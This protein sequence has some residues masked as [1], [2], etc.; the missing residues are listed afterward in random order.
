MTDVLKIIDD[1]FADERELLDETGSLRL[2]AQMLRDLEPRLV[3]VADRAGNVVAAE[4]ATGDT[5]LCA[6]EGFGA[7][8]AD[9][10]ADRRSVI[11][12][13]PLGQDLFYGFGLRLAS[14]GDG[15]ILGVL[16]ERSEEIES[17]LDGLQGVL[18]ACGS[19]AWTVIRTQQRNDELRARIRHLVAEQDTVKDSLE[20]S[21]ATVIEEREE[22]I[23]EQRDYVVHLEGEVERRSAALRE[24]MERAEE[25][26]RAKSE[27]LANMSHEIRTPMT[28]ILGFA[29]LLRE[30]ETLD[31]APAER[32][33]AIDAIKRNG[34]HLLG[35]INDLLDLSKIEAGKLEIENIRCSPARIIA[36][37]A[38][39]MSVQ[40][41]AR[42]L[43]LS[44][45]YTGPIPD[46]IQSDP[47]R[48]RQI[49]VNLVGNAIK[50]TDE[51]SVKITV[52][53]LTDFPAKPM[54]QFEVIDTGIGIAPQEIRRLFRAFSQ[55]D[56]ST[57]RR[58]GGTGLGLAICKR[59]TEMLGGEITVTSIPGEGSRFRATIATGPLDNVTM[60]ARP[61]QALSGT[62]TTTTAPTGRTIQGCR[63][64]LAEDAP[65]NQRLISHILRRA[66][67]EVAVAANGQIAVN[68]ALAASEE[69]S[70][71]DI[72]LMDMQMPVLDGYD[73]TQR[74]RSEGYRGPVIALTA[75]AM[76]TDRD[77][78]LDAGCD[79][80]ATKPIERKNLMAIIQKYAPARS[81]TAD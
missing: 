34:T 53:L 21:I 14:H 73:A 8:L 79:D 31:L 69:G 67:A 11:F 3:L 42:S 15:G 50:F 13:K 62:E 48:L 5:E 30:Q 27:F 49:L 45:E 2:I 77:K 66:G 22:R 55:G 12:E 71:F 44:V 35:I 56:A 63:I 6:I 51:G 39:L 16:V 57:T 38:S 29:E 68:L 41:E 59:L 7:D 61:E 74:L 80:Y 9:Y 19:L 36:D 37:V 20:R 52:R 54:I 40:A 81:E 60:L 32:M 65:D 64:L 28:A 4:D 1:L 24:A 70:P 25:A 18:D 72:I 78:C 47:T 33:D 75:H 43:S 46:R 17:R 23:R 76:A 10:L 58:Y 26:N